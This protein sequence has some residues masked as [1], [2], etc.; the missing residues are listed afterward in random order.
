MGFSSLTREIELGSPALGVWSLSHW[1]TREVPQVQFLRLQIEHFTYRRGE[2]HFQDRKIHTSPGK[3]KWIHFQ[4]NPL[5][6][7]ERKGRFSHPKKLLPPF[8]LFL[9]TDFCLIKL[10]PLRH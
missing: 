5:N 8:L 4:G 7:N 6:E 3:W 10:D 2:R 1:T 9:E